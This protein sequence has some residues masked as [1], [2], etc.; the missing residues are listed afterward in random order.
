MD[1]NIK[2]ERPWGPHRHQPP[3]VRGHRAKENYHHIIHYPD[4]YT[5]KKLDGKTYIVLLSMLMDHTFIIYMRF[6]QPDINQNMFSS[7]V[8][9]ISVTKLG[10]RHPVTGRKV[11]EGVGGGSKQKARWIDWLRYAFTGLLRLIIAN[12]FYF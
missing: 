10:G 1:Y 4:E 8:L 5:T 12:M 7:Q 6:I 3:N 11:I 2:R 9:L